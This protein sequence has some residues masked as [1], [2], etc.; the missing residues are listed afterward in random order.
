MD[1][2]S[3]PR[4]LPKALRVSKNPKDGEEYAKLLEND[5]QQRELGEKINAPFT[6]STPLE[7]QRSK[8]LIAIK[9]ME[10]ATGFTRS[11]LELLAEQYAI[12]GRYDTAMAL[13][14]ENA[15]LYL[16]YWRAVWLDDDVWC[17]HA[18]K[19]KYIRENVYSMKEKREMPLLACNV[20]DTW[21][22][23]DADHFL[24][25]NLSREVSFQGATAGMTIEQARKWHVNNMFGKG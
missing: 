11:T 14:L 24:K 17:E 10:Q 23:R 15:K 18:D 1:D 6:R 8:A 20:C 9:S 3:K 7:A 2:D 5:E 25:N 19:H 21:N 13:T 16:K 4:R 22:V 12:L